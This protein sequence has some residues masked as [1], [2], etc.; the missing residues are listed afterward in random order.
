[1]ETTT[2]KAKRWAFQKANKIG[3]EGNWEYISVLNAFL[4]FP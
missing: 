3:Q 2:G 4:F 1:M